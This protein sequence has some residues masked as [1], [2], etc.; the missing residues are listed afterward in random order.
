VDE[1]GDRAPARLPIVGAWP[2]GEYHLLRSKRAEMAGDLGV[3]IREMQEALRFLG[4][5]PWVHDR[6]ADLF[7][8][9]DDKSA[10]RAGATK[11]RAPS[12]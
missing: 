10:E 2:R 5:V 4:H 7:F 9:T 3:A 1:R 8:R 12:R 6:L 11:A